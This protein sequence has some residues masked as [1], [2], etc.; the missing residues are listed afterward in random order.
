MESD[1][2]V[3]FCSEIGHAVTDDL[4]GCNDE[5]VSWQNCVNAT[6]PGATNWDCNAV[7]EFGFLGSGPQST[8]CTQQQTAYTNCL[9]FGDGA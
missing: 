6:P 9:V 4:P 5:R 2:C 7:D 3:S 8:M 1:A